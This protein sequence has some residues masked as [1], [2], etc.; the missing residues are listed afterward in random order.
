M[1]E[2]VLMQYISYYFTIY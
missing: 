1:T 2:I